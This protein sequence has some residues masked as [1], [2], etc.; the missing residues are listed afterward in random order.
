M[1]IV[2]LCALL[3]DY[4]FGEPKKYHPLVGFGRL[5]NYLEE[6]LNEDL[7][8]KKVGFNP[9][10]KPQTTQQNRIN[11]LIAVLVCLVP[12]WWLTHLIISDGLLSMLL[13][14]IIL[15]LALGLSSLKE[16][17]QQVLKPLQENQLDQARQALAMIVSRD[18]QQM[19]EEGICRA[20]TESVLE[21][22]SDAVFATIFW[23]LVAG[24]PGVVVYRLS[25]TLDAMWGYKTDR[26]NNFGFF[27][28]KFD[29]L[30][31]FIPARLTALTYA[32]M[33]NWKNAMRCWSK[34]GS[35]WES[36]N[37][38]V[39]MAAGAGALDVQLGG[40]DHYH[41]ELKQRTDLG[42]GEKAQAATI[43]QSC[44]LL[45]RSIIVWVVVVA[46]ICI[47]VWLS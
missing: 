5:A 18:T 35:L 20:A 8:D 17:A 13:E 16:H 37:A 44:Q 11:G 45:D 22:G 2:L 7:L 30:L 38:G 9:D 12:A 47:P 42:C 14:T 26:Y 4:F 1:L 33:G 24:A 6:R 29:D 23:F 40:A 36:P 32:L 39:V 27:V 15:Y 46:L 10:K 31:N 28:A 34:Q 19:D 25:N 3:L 41:G 43:E 21:N